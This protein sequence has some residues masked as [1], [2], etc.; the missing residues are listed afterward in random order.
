MAADQ[1]K[2]NQEALE[3]RFDSTELTLLNVQTGVTSLE[4]ER[5][6]GVDLMLHIVDTDRA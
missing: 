1:L 5:Q 3:R 4:Q 6:G 2:H